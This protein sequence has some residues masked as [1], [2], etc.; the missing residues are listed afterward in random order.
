MDQ[1]GVRLGF[2]NYLGLARARHSTFCGLPA[3]VPIRA[4]SLSQNWMRET[5]LWRPR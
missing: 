5:Q 2:A 4:I 3:I 1:A